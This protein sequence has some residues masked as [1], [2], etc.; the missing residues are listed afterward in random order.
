MN[1]R[2]LKLDAM[3]K[4]SK[5]YLSN[6]PNLRRHS[7]FS[8]II[9]FLISG[10][11]DSEEFAIE[12]PEFLRGE[13]LDENTYRVYPEN[14]DNF[15]VA[16]FRLW[17]PQQ[18]EAIR[19]VLVLLHSH[20]SNGLGLADAPEWQE[21]AGKQRLAILAVHLKSL[22]PATGF[23]G[24]ARDGSGQALLEA[25]SAL[26]ERK[27]VAYANELPFLLRGYSAGGIFSHSFSQFLPER[28]IAFVNIRGGGLGEVSPVNRTIPVLMFYGAYD[29]EQ[30]NNHI[31]EMV[32][33]QRENGG[34]WGLVREEVDHYGG[35]EKPDGLIREFFVKALE[36]RSTTNPSILTEPD[37]A[38]GWLG[39]NETFG[40][41]P[42]SL[43]PG[44]QVEAS[45]LIDAAFARKWQEFQTIVD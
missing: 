41:Y 15:D 9:I 33:R 39:N 40:I 30:R 22:N 25:L 35:M 36:I 17:L 43:Y 37:E 29:L 8:F 32:K 27:N 20:N 18:E 26:A 7:L 5:F 28:V 13:F 19:A 3:H 21:F 31:L 45:W 6:Y 34:R 12:E 1:Y 44:N 14:G 42:F 16:E 11:G 24:D 23:Y 10:C 4:E 38:V 2:S